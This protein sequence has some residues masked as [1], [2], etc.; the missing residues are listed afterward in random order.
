[1]VDIL[2]GACSQVK[3]NLF[4]KKLLSFTSF[5]FHRLCLS[6]TARVTTMYQH[7]WHYPVKCKIVQWQLLDSKSA[8]LPKTMY[9]T[10]MLTN[11]K[12][13]PSKFIF[14][15][16]DPMWCLANGVLKFIAVFAINIVSRY[17]CSVSIQLS[18]SVVIVCGLISQSF[19]R[20]LWKPS[21]L[22]MGKSEL[23]EME[24]FW[25]T[26]V[27]PWTCWRSKLNFIRLPHNTSWD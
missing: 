21:L 16:E 15:F 24:C 9:E 13:P 26:N 27:A 10:L 6:L 14:N 7:V 1:M 18:V 5:H 4:Q 12:L 22:A 23:W 17:S 8:A 2:N 11:H 3:Y 25:N 19:P 20:K